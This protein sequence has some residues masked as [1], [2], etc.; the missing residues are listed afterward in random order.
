MS[1]EHPSPPAG[2]YYEVVFHLRNSDQKH[3]FFVPG[4]TIEEAK[5]QARELLVADGQDPAHFVD[6]DDPQVLPVNPR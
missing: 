1:S 2:A 4:P 6:A 5:V 3:G